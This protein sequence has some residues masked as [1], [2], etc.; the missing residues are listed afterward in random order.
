MSRKSVSYLTIIRAEVA[1]SNRDM[2]EAAIDFSN[3]A[4]DIEDMSIDMIR[5]D[6]DS[7]YKHYMN[8]ERD[9]QVAIRAHKA[10]VK[11]LKEFF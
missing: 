4:T 11:K 8:S 7:Q 3:A 9:L 5:T 10:A 2:M 1:Q 6:D